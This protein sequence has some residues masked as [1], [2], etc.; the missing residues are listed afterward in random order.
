MLTTVAWGSRDDLRNVVRIASRGRLRWEVEPIPLRN[1]A[2]AHA[3]LRERKV[4]GR[5]VLVP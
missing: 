5:F 3:R 1:A 2:K 4:D